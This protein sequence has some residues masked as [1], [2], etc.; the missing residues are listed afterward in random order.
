MLLFLLYLSLW[1]LW[2]A[3]CR[4]GVCEGDRYIVRLSVVLFCRPASRALL[5]LFPACVL[6][7]GG[8]VYFSFFSVFVCFLPTGYRL[9]ISLLRGQPLGMDTLHELTYG[10]S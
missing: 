2:P 3:C 6:R 1:W 9:A 8:R 7:I 10:S 4:G 5:V